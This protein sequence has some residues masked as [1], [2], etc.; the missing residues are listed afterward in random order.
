M[1]DFTKEELR[2]VGSLTRQPEFKVFMAWLARGLEQTHE[3]IYVAVADRDTQVLVGAAREV[4]DIIR[5]VDQAPLRL[6]NEQFPT[7]KET[8]F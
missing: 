2:S 4:R 6:E 8:M 1:T 7:A 3:K 5:K